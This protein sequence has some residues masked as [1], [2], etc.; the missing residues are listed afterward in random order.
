MWS[1]WNLSA[2]HD[3]EQVI[4]TDCIEVDSDLPQSCKDFVEHL[5]TLA[6]PAELKVVRLYSEGTVEEALL[7]AKYKKI[8]QTCGKEGVVLVEDLASDVAKHIFG[9]NNKA[10]S[11]ISFSDSVEEDIA[12]EQ[13]RMMHIDGFVQDNLIEKFDEITVFVKDVSLDAMLENSEDDD[14]EMDNVEDDVDTEDMNDNVGLEYTPL[15]PIDEYSKA[16]YKC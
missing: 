2:F 11:N 12:E 1:L 10:F 5:A 6:R 9:D 13:S 4:F 7:K 15:M 14:V 3:V 8:T 16:F